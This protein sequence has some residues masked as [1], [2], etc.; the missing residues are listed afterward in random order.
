M[1]AS[2]EKPAS[3]SP[4]DGENILSE[5]SMLYSDVSAWREDKPVVKLKSDVLKL[6]EQYGAPYAPEDNTL[7]NWLALS[8]RVH[9]FLWAYKF[10]SVSG[11]EAL[12][13]EVNTRLDTIKVTARE[14]IRYTLD[15]SYKRNEPKYWDMSEQKHAYFG[16]VNIKVAKDRIWEEEIAALEALTQESV[17]YARIKPDGSHLNKKYKIYTTSHKYRLNIADNFLLPRI[18]TREI[19]ENYGARIIL[20][21]DTIILSCPVSVWVDFKLAEVW[22]YGAEVR[23]CPICHSIFIRS[24]NNMK[25]C[26]R[27]TCAYKQHKLNKKELEKQNKSR[28]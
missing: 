12:M 8:A 18:G 13:A 2:Y 1:R 10:L 25:Y 15:R 5:L 17:N 6:A 7:E 4:Q 14:F 24:R 19:H 20:R 26:R 28:L 11:A 16:Q 23:K 21:P 27:G 22:R 3:E 9:T